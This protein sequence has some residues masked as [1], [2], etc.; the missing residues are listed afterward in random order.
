[1]H[2][3]KP[4]KH[5]IVHAGI[6]IFGG[7]LSSQVIRLVSN[8]IM[9]R[10]LVPEMFGLMAIVNV[11]LVGLVLLTDLGLRQN[12]IQ[13]K[14]AHEEIFLNT[15]WA[16]QIM[17]GIF[18]WGVSVLVAICFYFGQHFHWLPD[19]TVY[20]ESLLPFIIPV[21][22]LAMVISAFEPT[23]TALASRNLQQAKLIKIEV[24][25]QLVGVM[26]MVPLAFYY[27]SIWALVFGSLAS[28]LTRSIIV[29]FIIKEKRNRFEIDKSALSEIFHFGKWV[30]LSSIVGFLI[31]NG[32]RLIL[33]GLITA[34]E[35]GV[36]SI[37]AFIIGAVSTVISRM[38]GNV[39]YPAL[40]E[41]VRQAPHDLNRV[42]YRFRVPFDAGVMFLAGF[43]LITGQTIIDHLYDA[44]YQQAGWML[45]ILSLSLIALRYNLTDQCYMALGKP[46]VMTVLI[47]V[48]TVSMFILVPL[49]FKF[50]SMQGAIWAMVFSYFSSFPLAIYYKKTH[51]LLDI[52][53]EFITLPMVL[54]GLL[55]G[56]IFNKIMSAI[57]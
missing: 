46:K 3:S 49:A 17:R 23:W 47:V 19:N 39:A 53:K 7:H 41:K 15:V 29:N 13:S 36:Y 20:S 21:S 31:N 16:F 43:F 22:T 28:S 5:R 1:M 50:Y 52:K 27:R 2:H 34:R 45:S 4:L 9:T 55:C 25:S 14:R 26:L 12:I 8:L 24:F 35:L 42:Y 40:S 6:W 33:G 51:H 57:F 32:D 48:R 56:F 37:A 11:L 18:I 54:V 30:F 44:R 10:L 38:L